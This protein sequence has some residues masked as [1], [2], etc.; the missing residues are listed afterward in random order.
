MEMICADVMVIVKVAVLRLIAVPMDGLVAS[1]TSGCVLGAVGA[2]IRAR[3]AAP[4]RNPKKK[5]MRKKMKKHLNNYFLDFR[6]DVF[7]RCFRWAFLERRPPFFLGNVNIISL[8]SST[9]ASCSAL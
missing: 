2:T 1:V 5:M 6:F 8:V 4:E 9:L 7:L 3:N